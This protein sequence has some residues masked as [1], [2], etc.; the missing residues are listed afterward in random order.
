MPH[1]YIYIYTYIYGDLVHERYKIL[2]V[3]KSGYW[4][5]VLGK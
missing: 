4:N 5:T 2:F 1:I 3:K